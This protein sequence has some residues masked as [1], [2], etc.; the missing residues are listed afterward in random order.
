MEG[1][2][3]CSRVLY[4]HDL[5]Q[6]KKENV[7]LKNEIKLLKGPKIILKNCDESERLKNIFYEKIDTIINTALN[8]A[9]TYQLQHWGVSDGTIGYICQNIQ[10]ELQAI[11]GCKE[12]SEQKSFGT[13]WNII[14][15]LFHSFQA[16]DVWDMMYEYMD[17]GLIAKMV[18]ENAYW[19][20][21]N[22]VFSKIFEYQCSRCRSIDIYID[23][24]DLCYECSE[25]NI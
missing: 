16:C 20:F 18:Y 1:L 2:A 5:L 19:Y 8:Q 13:L 23:E 15:G 10:K 11:T 4:D 6:T 12:W 17:R 7:S 3:L 22:N 14:S 24:S 9:N 25:K 21:E